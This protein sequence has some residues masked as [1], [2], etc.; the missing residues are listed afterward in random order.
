MGI[1]LFLIALIFVVACVFGGGHSDEAANYVGNSDT[2]KFHRAECS[3][4][5]KMN[6]DHVVLLN[7][8]E[9]AISSGYIPC[10][11]CRP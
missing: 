8:R 5:Q 1:I 3:Q 6:P 11:I 10:K 2:G 7:S 9:A 4:V